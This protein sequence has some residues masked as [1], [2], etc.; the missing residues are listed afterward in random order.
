MFQADLSDIV[1]LTIPVRIPRYR[2]II[3]GDF[4]V[5]GSP[6]EV[7]RPARD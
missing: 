7:A 1:S 3:A 2:L 4:L 6:G 5:I